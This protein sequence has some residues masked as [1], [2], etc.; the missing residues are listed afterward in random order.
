M[1]WFRLKRKGATPPGRGDRVARDVHSRM[2][3]VHPMPTHSAS[4]TKH[5][6]RRNSSN[7]SPEHIGNLMSSPNLHVRMNKVS[8]RKEEFLAAPRSLFQLFPRSSIRDPSR[9]DF[10]FS[11]SST[12]YV[13]VSESLLDALR[14]DDLRLEP[15]RSLIMFFFFFVFSFFFSFP[16]C[17]MKNRQK[18]TNNGVA[19]NSTGQL[20][21]RSVVGY[22]GTI[23]MPEDSSSQSSPSS[24]VSGGGLSASGSHSN[25]NN[26]AAARLAAIR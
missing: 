12:S 5:R 15:S 1:S 21:Y 26:S 9:V 16:C 19:T 10:V 11:L 4:G 22:L 8:K 3:P 6:R 7:S 25:S 23:E 2:M 18:K 24:G 17:F 13:K 14:R 20:M